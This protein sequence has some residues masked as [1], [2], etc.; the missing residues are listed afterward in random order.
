MGRRPGPSIEH[1][2]FTKT[3]QTERELEELLNHLVH[4]YQWRVINVI[5]KGNNIYQ[6]ILQRDIVPVWKE[7]RVAKSVE[8]QKASV[9]TRRREDAH[10]SSL[11]DDIQE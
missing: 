4:E 10:T 7:D 2:V 1:R 9:G 11:E 5:N 8:R 6:L 3:F